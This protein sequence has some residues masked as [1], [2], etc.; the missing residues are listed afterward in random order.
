ME[1][2]RVTELAP[3]LVNAHRELARLALGTRDWAGAVQHLD[4][5][6]IWDPGDRRAREDRSR[7]L[8]SV[9]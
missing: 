4:Q 6:L 5:V 1:F 3:G 8:A 7:V 9:R 2:R